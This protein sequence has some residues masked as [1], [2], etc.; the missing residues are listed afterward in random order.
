MSDDENDNEND[1]DGNEQPQHAS[2]AVPTTVPILHVYHA[3]P[4]SIARC[5]LIIPFMMFV[6]IDYFLNVDMR[7]IQRNNRSRRLP[8]ALVCIG[9]IAYER[10]RRHWR[11][12]YNVN[13]IGIIS[14]W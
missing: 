13:L 11:S 4:P 2:A 1:N 12:L 14:E 3:H 5:L 7:M 10:S 6:A 9:A 8:S